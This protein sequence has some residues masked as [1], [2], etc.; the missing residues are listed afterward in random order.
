MI[1][2]GWRIG[3]GGKTRTGQQPWVAVRGTVALVD[4][5]DAALKVRIDA[6]AVYDART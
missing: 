5:T 1:Y 2:R 6:R 3:R 4:L